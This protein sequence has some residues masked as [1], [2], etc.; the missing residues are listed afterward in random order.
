MIQLVYLRWKVTFLGHALN[1]FSPDRCYC[2]TKLPLNLVRDTEKKS[3]RLIFY[4]YLKQANTNFIVLMKSMPSMASALM[5]FMSKYD[6]ITALNEK[7][8]FSTFH[9]K[10]VTLTTL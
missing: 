5:T 2:L 6:S 10:I 3:N 7:S 4:K 9:L 8:N 1:P